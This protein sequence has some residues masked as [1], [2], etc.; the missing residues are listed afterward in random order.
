M[1]QKTIL[2]YYA[3][4]SDISGETELQELDFYLTGFRR[5]KTK[6]YLY[7]EDRLRSRLSELLLLVGISDLLGKVTVSLQANSYGKPFLT[8]VEDIHFNISHSGEYVACAFFETEIGL[9]VERLETMSDYSIENIVSFFS[10]DEQEYILAEKGL[11]KSFRLFQVWTIK[12]AYLKY[13]GQG[14]SKSL[15][16]FSLNCEILPGYFQLAEEIWQAELEDS[17]IIQSKLGKKH[18]LALSCDTPADLDFRHIDFSQIS[19]V[20]TRLKASILDRN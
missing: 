17:F 9:D 2:I 15:D 1:I 20:K 7:R 10:E 16:S 18:L 11:A 19:N 3:V 5:S 13:L 14:L 12:E 8:D 6:R 4:L